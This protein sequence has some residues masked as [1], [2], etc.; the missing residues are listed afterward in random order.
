MTALKLA[1]YI[2]LVTSILA[3]I[4]ML[5][6]V[7]KILEEIYF[8]QLFLGTAIS[9]ILYHLGDE[10]EKKMIKEENR[11]KFGGGAGGG[12]GAGTCQ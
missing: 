2:V 5:F 3:G 11:K 10:K 7:D 6:T 4:Q 8:T 12:G 9:M 1:S